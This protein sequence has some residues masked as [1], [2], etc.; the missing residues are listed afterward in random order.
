MNKIITISREFGSGGREVGKRLADKLNFA[1]YDREIIMAISKETGLSEQYIQNVSEKGIYPCAFQ[2]ARLF[3][4]YSALQ[5]NQTEILV[6]EQKIIKEIAKKGNC[7][8]VGRGADII[9]KKYNPMNIF[10]YANMESKLNRCKEKAE[11]N[12]NLTDKEIKNKIIQIDKDRKNYH[13]IISNLEW[14]DKRNYHLCINTSGIE[15]KTIIPSL[16]VYIENW[17]GGK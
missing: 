12:E 17:F 4:M 8:I 3:T 5:S 1:Y 2:F 13:N 6:T 14:G 16:A 9:L 15:I 7:I 11:E 10:I